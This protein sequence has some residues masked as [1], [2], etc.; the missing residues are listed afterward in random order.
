MSGMC[1]EYAG[2]ESGIERA[3]FRLWEDE[4][5]DLQ[6]KFCCKDNGSF[7]S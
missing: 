1:G 6:E 5:Q 4:S 2:Q 7:A 3:K